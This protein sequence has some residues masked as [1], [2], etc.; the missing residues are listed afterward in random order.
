MTALSEYCRPLGVCGVMLVSAGLTMTSALSPLPSALSSPANE[1]L[2]S[3]GTSRGAW[4]TLN[5]AVEIASVPTS[6]V[7]A[8]FCVPP[9]LKSTVF[10]ASAPAAVDSFAVTV[11]VPRYVA[12]A[13][14]L[15]KSEVDVVGGACVAASSR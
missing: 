1:A 6:A 10:P 4:V 2:T 8:L 15:T 11:S 3:Y 14:A 9:N 12:V 13:G 5:V 7:R